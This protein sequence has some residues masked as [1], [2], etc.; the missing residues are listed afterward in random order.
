MTPIHG[1]LKNVAINGNQ[2]TVA[3]L[4][5]AL[6]FF[7]DLSHIRLL[8]SVDS[9]SAV[10]RRSM[11]EASGVLHHHRVPV[12]RLS[13]EIPPQA[14]AALAPSQAGPE[15]VLGHRSRNELPPFSGDTPQG[16]QV[17]EPASCGRYVGQSRRFRNLLPGVSVRRREGLHGHVPMDGS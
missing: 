4:H 5:F 15:A 1:Q 8:S 2:E 9:A 13:E 14:G 16:S 3:L 6:F 12:W 7:P 11:Q 10:V 17:R